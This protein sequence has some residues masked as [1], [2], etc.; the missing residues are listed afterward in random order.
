[1]NTP[2]MLNINPMLDLTIK[3][4]IILIGAGFSARYVLTRKTW[5]A[6]LIFIFL[7]SLLALPLFFSI[8][9]WAEVSHARPILVAVILS[10]FILSPLLEWLDEKR[11][12]AEG[13]RKFRQSAH[14]IE[15]TFQALA[16]EKI[17]A[18]VAIEREDGLTQIT[19]KGIPVGGEITKE[20][21]ATLFTPYTPTHDG[22]IVIRDGKI[23]SCGCVFPLSANEHL[24]KDFG[25]R[26]RAGLGLSEKSDAL[27][28]IASE[29]S[30]EIA[31]ASYGKLE[32]NV[33]PESLEKK[34]L[35]ALG[36]TRHKARLN[37]PAIGERSL[38][39]T[40]RGALSRA[41]FSKSLLLLSG[42][43]FFGAL[44]A[45]FTP[46]D[47]AHTLWGWVCVT[48][49]ATCLIL[50][51]Q[52]VS[53]AETLFHPEMRQ[54]ER[55]FAF[56]GLSLFKRRYLYDKLHGMNIIASKQ[57]KNLYELRLAKNRFTSWLIL[58]SKNLEKL[59]KAKLALDPPRPSSNF[60][61]TA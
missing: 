5:L 33:S 57:W 18:L 7:T 34:I 32:H 43:A 45:S 36:K 46:K 52:L 1:L 6:P 55:I 60:G 49:L 24:S 56:L 61:A 28:L 21:L 54:V 31:I 16:R 13:R 59:E 38:H 22:G 19:K 58:D 50:L 14:E 41:S 48:P 11:I 8:D 10:F 2:I 39:F 25:T 12:E 53:G 15:L 30:G 3:A 27:V 9:L 44:F 23:A 17:G 20:L 47:M 37:F 4:L 35:K 42:I 40:K 51:A 26:H 29:E